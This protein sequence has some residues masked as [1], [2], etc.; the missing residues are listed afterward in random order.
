MPPKQVVSIDPDTIYRKETPLRQKKF[1]SRRRSLRSSA[2]GVPAPVRQQSTLTQQPDWIVSRTSQTSDEEYEEDELQKSR[3][4]RKK[5]KSS[6]DGKKQTTMSQYVPSSFS[7][8]QQYHGPAR[9]LLTR[10]L[11]HDQSHGIRESHLSSSFGQ[12]QDQIMQQSSSGQDEERVD[13]AFSKPQVRPRSSPSPELSAPAMHLRTPK[14]RLVSE[15]PSS[16]TP[17]SAIVSICKYQTTRSPERSPLKGR[18]INNPLDT[19]RMSP[20]PESPIKP[21]SPFRIS[22]I[23]PQNRPVF[24][25]PDKPP[26]LQHRSTIPDSEDTPTQV[27]PFKKAKFRSQVPDTQMDM[28]G[29]EIDPITATQY[30]AGNYTQH[31]GE[32]YYAENDNYSYNFDPVC[33]A[34]D[35]DAARFM[36]TQRLRDQVS[37]QVFHK[38]QMFSEVEDEQIQGAEVPGRATIQQSQEL[39][40]ELPVL[41]SHQQHTEEEPDDPPTQSPQSSPHRPKSQYQSDEIEE[42]DLTGDVILPKNSA[43]E[44]IRIASSPSSKSVSSGKY[45]SSPPL[46]VE[47]DARIRAEAETQRVATERNSSPPLVIH[48]PIAPSQVSTIGG[49]QLN[50]FISSHGRASALLSS[51]PPPLP[52]ST[53][54]PPPEARQHLR[55][56]LQMYDSDSEDDADTPQPPLQEDNDDDNDEEEGMD[57]DFVSQSHWE[58]DDHVRSEHD[59]EFEDGDEDHTRLSDILPD[60]LLDFSLPPPPTQS[61]VRSSRA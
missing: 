2:V 1:P 33:S 49:T 26:T 38:A 9:H 40:D 30:A 45:P 36:Q 32:T 53:S 4:T 54:S 8:E 16:N 28:F 34:L 47:N 61:S 31:G 29:E 13:S 17:Q 35:R 11:Q 3:P 55:K 41:P 50:H 19:A 20:V 23:K 25:I 42:L 21:I 27:T 43:V 56:F 5:R 48:L 18:S 44:I 59:D 58:D 24:I 15:I 14:R 12:D 7:G 10:V 57:F 46:V 60:T 22:P 52:P 39:G 6:G 37:Y 51:S